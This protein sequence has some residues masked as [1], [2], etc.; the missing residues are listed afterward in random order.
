MCNYSTRLVSWMDGELGEHEAA[1]VRRHVGSCVECR[2]RVSSYESVSRELGAYYLA[3]TQVSAETA[4]H[5]K[6]PRWVPAAAGVAAAFLIVLALMPR[7]ARQVPSVPQV[8]AMTPPTIEVPA[9]NPVK[10]VQRT[11][12]AAH[13]KAR[14]TNWAMVGPA[15]QIAIP[16]DSMFP[17]GAVP[18]GVTYIANLSF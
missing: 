17:P 6:L 3:S 10:P 18:E 9:V 15:I 16:A 12:A 7:S 8:A 13:R 14:T 5:R 2:E 4:G 1:E 11:H